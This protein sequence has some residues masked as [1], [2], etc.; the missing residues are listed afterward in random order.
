MHKRSQHVPHV[1]I[2]IETSRTYGRGLLRGIRRYLSTQGPWSVFVELRALESKAPPWLRSWRGDGILTRT[3]SQA[4]LDSISAVNVPTVELRAARLQHSFPFVGIDNQVLG[5]MVAEHFLERG[6][7]H[8]AIYD[9]DTE[10]YFIERR[11]S[12]LNT[13]KQAGYV[14]SVHSVPGHRESPADWERHQELLIRWLKTL[15]KP[16]G[17]MAST[18][19]LGFWLLDACD[20][21]GIAVPEE[22]AVVGG[23]NDETLCEVSRPPMSSVHPNAESIG[24]QAAT[25]LESMMAGAKPPTAPILVPPLRIAVRQSSDIMAIDDSELVIALRFIREHACKEISVT[26]ILQAVPVSR[27]TL[28]RK[29]R[30]TLGRSPR[31]EILRLKLEHVKK[32]LQETDF[33]LDAIAQRTG[34]RH[35]QSL[36]ER[37]RLE[38]GLTPGDYRSR[39]RGD[40]ISE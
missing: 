9:L 24:F 32:L 33:T 11:E 30:Q 18:D 23:E 25:L 27:S 7:R 28:E 40:K 2:L 20:R 5:K 8:F 10:P 31:A 22:V 16:V 35:A 38:L 19:Q 13:I 26:D 6:F 17:L 37:F 29:M 3:G 15:P 21:A 34:F 36:C 12:F 4:M 1:A 39:S 14:V